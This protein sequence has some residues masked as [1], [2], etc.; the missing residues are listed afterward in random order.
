MV[1]G[2]RALELH[3]V[4]GTSCMPLPRMWQY[5]N[6]GPCMAHSLHGPSRPTL[7]QINPTKIPPTTSS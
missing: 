6:H 5:T 2:V 4:Q 1:S 7:I 3:C